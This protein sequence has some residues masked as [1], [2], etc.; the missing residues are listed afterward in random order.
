M[1]VGIWNARPK[2]ITP[3]RAKQM[4]WQVL[5]LR[6]CGDDDVDTGSSHARASATVENLPVLAFVG[7]VRGHRPLPVP[8]TSVHLTRA[9]ERESGI[10]FS[11]SHRTKIAATSS[12]ESHNNT[13]K[14]HH[15][16]FDD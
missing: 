6:H 13:S 5:A 7:V 16:C 3:V 8:Q 12:S 10:T 4:A 2:K 1:K 15:S 14:H 11:Q 9:A